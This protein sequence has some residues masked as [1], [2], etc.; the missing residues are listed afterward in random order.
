MMNLTGFDWEL[1]VSMPSTAT[2]SPA[3]NPGDTIRAAELRRVKALATLL[4]AGCLGVFI[5]A[6]SLLHAHPVFGFI[7]ALAEAATIG[8]LADW[9]AVVERGSRA[10]RASSVA[11]GHVS[12]RNIGPQD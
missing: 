7:A 2:F 5:A 1:Q 11:R 10:L 3:V 8:G 12:H 6:K 4:L 9:Y